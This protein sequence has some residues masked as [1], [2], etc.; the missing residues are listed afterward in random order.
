M[1]YR[2]I[3]DHDHDQP[4]LSDQA[5]YAANAMHPSTAAREMQGVKSWGIAKRVVSIKY[6]A[7]SRTGRG[8]AR[9]LLITSL[10]PASVLANDRVRAVTPSGQAPSSATR[11]GA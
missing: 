5:L 11:D 6:T 2:W 1:P 7:S 8:A 3:L 10:P 4:L 9:E